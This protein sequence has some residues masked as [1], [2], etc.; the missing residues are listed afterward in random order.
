M[1]K[2]MK[3]GFLRWWSKP[4]RPLL[5]LI[6]TII[7]SMLL[8]AGST[9]AWYINTDGVRNDFPGSK[10]TF[11]I[12][13]IDVFTP[14]T[15]PPLP[16]ESFPKTVSATNTGEIPGFVRILVE[17]IIFADDS[18]GATP[19]PAEIGVQVKLD[20]N[21]TDWILGEDGYY[22]YLGLLGPGKTAPSLFTTV[23]L[24][25]PLGLEYQNATLK[26]EVKVEGV[27]YYKWNYRNA[28]WEN[29]AVPP[30][31]SSALA[32]VEGTLSALAK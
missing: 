24:A 27:D 9:L 13:V 10:L 18:D 5:L 20:I 3:N 32:T 8:V 22:Y 2:R 12:E 11:N 26:I 7:V 6:P 15:T 21:L 31:G 4:V 19:L 14:P 17:P 30:S 16:G 29:P 1:L 28:W 23:E 25:N